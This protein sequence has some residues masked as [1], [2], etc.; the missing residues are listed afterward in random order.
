[1]SRSRVLGAGGDASG[2]SAVVELLDE[3]TDGRLTTVINVGAVPFDA[4][5]GAAVDD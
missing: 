5:I 4:G 3:G 2:G 1:V